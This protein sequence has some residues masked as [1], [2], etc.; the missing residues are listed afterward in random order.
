MVYRGHIAN[1]AVVVDDAV[2]LPD[3]A[4][5]EIRVVSPAARESVEPRA[6]LQFSG[7]IDDLPPD[8]SQHIDE[9]LYGRPE[10]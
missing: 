6:W 1:G 3:G 10:P 8:A 9:A 2:V 4:E 5:V 7:V